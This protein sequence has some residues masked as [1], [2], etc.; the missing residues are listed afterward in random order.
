MEEA[1]ESKKEHK[2]EEGSQRLQ[3]DGGVKPE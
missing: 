2:G 1:K 3:E